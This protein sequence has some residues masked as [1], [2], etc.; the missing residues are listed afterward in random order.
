[1][2][3]SAPTKPFFLISLVLFVLGILGLFFVGALGEYASWFLIIAWT[4]LAAGCVLK[5]A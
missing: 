5:G 3:L 1:M 2:N 4:L